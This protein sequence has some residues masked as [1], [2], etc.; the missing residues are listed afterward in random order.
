MQ[1]IVY[2][3]SV[4]CAAFS[5]ILL[6]V[7]L[8]SIATIIG[9]RIGI[10]KKTSGMPDS[11]I[12]TY[13]QINECDGNSEVKLREAPFR[14]RVD[15]LI[16]DGDRDKDYPRQCPSAK[17]IAEA[18]REIRRR[19]EYGI[20]K[21][22]P[23]VAVRLCRADVYA[24][25]ESVL[26]V[27]VFEIAVKVFIKIL[28]EVLVKVIIVIVVVVACGYS[29]ASETDINLV[30]VLGLYKYAGRSDLDRVF[31]GVSLCLACIIRRGIRVIASAL[32]SEDKLVERHAVYLR[33]GDQIIC[34]GARLTALP[35]GD[36]LARNAELLGKLLLREVILFSQFNKSVSCFNCHCFVL[37]AGFLQL[38][39]TKTRH[40]MLY[41]RAF[42]FATIGC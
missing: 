32:L 39:Y 31:L 9:S 21:V 13:V 41:I 2:E 38:D 4:F 30:A 24:S 20:G 35:L 28:V 42:R 36:R 1:T 25:L 37:S 26:L 11:V 10:A 18:K 12:K 19:A 40:A 15:Q 23:Y 6:R 17:N 7:M 16:V 3:I 8:L 5:A 27:L 22:E 34:I 33:Q 29:D 14:D